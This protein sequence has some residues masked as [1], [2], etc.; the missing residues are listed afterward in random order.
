[1]LAA[2]RA[3]RDEG[4]PGLEVPDLCGDGLR[5]SAG[6]EGEPAQN[7]PEKMWGMHCFLQTRTTGGETWEGRVGND[8]G[9]KVRR[10]L[11]EGWKSSR[12]PWRIYSIIYGL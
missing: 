3:T 6:G 9:G 12:F 8:S 2:G 7:A 5:E 10:R 11:A 4:L 1:M